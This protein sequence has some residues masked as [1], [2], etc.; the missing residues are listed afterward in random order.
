MPVNRTLPPDVD[1]YFNVIPKESK[2]S[3]GD[4]AFVG[5]VLLDWHQDVAQPEK[6][7]HTVLGAYLATVQSHYNLSVAQVTALSNYLKSQS[8]GISSF[9]S[10]CPPLSDPDATSKPQGA[11]SDCEYAPLKAL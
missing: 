7:L 5:N 11:G 6:P 4:R 3:D 2:D 1:H 9:H 10:S 8:N